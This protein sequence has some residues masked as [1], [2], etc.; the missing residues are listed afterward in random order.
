M[1]GGRA[2]LG[3]LQLGVLADASTLTK[4]AP[5]CCW[6]ARRERADPRLRRSADLELLEPRF[7]WAWALASS[8]ASSKSLL[9]VALMAWW[10]A[11]SSSRCA[12]RRRL[13][14]LFASWDAGSPL[15]FLPLEARIKRVACSYS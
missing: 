14:W 10:A 2:A 4:F 7:F 15:L 11:P 8:K 9:S 3:L 13:G 5:A 1:R 12:R 6:T